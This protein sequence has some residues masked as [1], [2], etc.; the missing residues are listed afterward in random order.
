MLIALINI[1]SMLVWIVWV[2]LIVQFVLSLLISFNVVNMHNNFVHSVWRAVNVVLDPMLNPI[3][4][5]LPQTGGIDFSP[6]VLIIL[7]RIVTYLL[8]GVA[9]EAAYRSYY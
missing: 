3:R 6:L 7:L 2:F 9:I 8:D 4:R 1:V 5:I